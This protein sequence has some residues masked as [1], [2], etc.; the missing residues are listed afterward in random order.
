[1]NIVER[2]VHF[3]SLYLHDTSLLSSGGE[4]IK[5]IQIKEIS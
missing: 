2:R 3:F 5:N 1:V 4:G